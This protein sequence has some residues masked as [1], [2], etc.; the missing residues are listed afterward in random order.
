MMRMVL[1]AVALSIAGHVCAQDA[2]EGIKGLEACF[3]A[4][5]LA[6][7]ICSS[8][9]NDS[10]QRLDCFKKTRAAQLECLQH[11]PLGMSV[12]S[13]ASEV[14][15]NANS[16]P[17]VSI[18][19]EAP[20]GSP[21]ESAG[22]DSQTTKNTGPA[23]PISPGAPA[24]IVSPEAPTGTISSP[25][26]SVL[27]P[28]PEPAPSASAT[29]NVPVD[30]PSAPQPVL[31]KEADD[32]GKSSNGNWVVSATTSPVDYGVLITATIH[33]ISGAKDTAST[34]IF[35]CHARQTEL[36]LRM[37]LAWSEMRSTDAQVEYQVNDQPPV[38]SKWALSADRK[39]LTYGDDGAGLLRSLPEGAKFKINVPDKPGVAQDSS[40]QLNGLDIVRKKIA[41]ACRWAPRQD[42]LSTGKR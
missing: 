38:R 20:A 5:R 13:K 40:F 19:P 9:A 11:V 22:R 15:K 34:L 2:N 28:A 23:S 8:P 1:A 4:A 17:D 30:K 7:A 14:P 39:T 3:Q 41:A 36:S 6:D 25:A 42:A 31:A 37:E 10:V 29:A 35:R 12:D 18:R 32:L 24:E 16:Q 21:N 33:S 26:G 27:P